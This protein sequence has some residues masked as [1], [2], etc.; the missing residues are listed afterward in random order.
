MSSVPLTILAIEHS[1]EGQPQC[2]RVAR[3]CNRGPGTR[4][5][6]LRPTRETCLLAGMLAPKLRYTFMNV[7]HI[8]RA[9]LT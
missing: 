3:C 4:L 7:L 5:R 9:N 1:E 2:R 8:S 6:N